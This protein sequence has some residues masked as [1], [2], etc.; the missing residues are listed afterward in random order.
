VAL[1]QIGT[2]EYLEYIPGS[3]LYLNSGAFTALPTDDPFAAWANPAQISNIGPR[4]SAG[5]Y[6]TKTDVA[7]YLDNETNYQSYSVAAGGEKG[8]FQYGVGLMH[9]GSNA[10]AFGL[11]DDFM[12][13]LSAGIGVDL[14]LQMNT[15]ITLKNGE[16]TAV[17]LGI[18]L[19]YPTPRF[20]KTSAEMSVGYAML[21][22]GSSIDIFGREYPYPRSQSLGYS[23]ALVHHFITPKG[24]ERTVRLDVSVD[25]N[26]KLVEP[27][28]PY[29]SEGRHWRYTSVLG[30]INV[31]DHLILRRSGDR[32]RIS[33]GWRLHIFDTFRIGRGRTEGQSHYLVN[34]SN[35]YEI[36]L[37]RVLK[38]TYD[39][40][41]PISLVYSYSTASFSAQEQVRT[42]Q[43]VSLGWGF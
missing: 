38:F 18:Q 1:G 29:P 42:F 40:D 3:G 39:F 35:G 13:A 10:R 24:P 26:D 12:T 41:T 15:G 20:M 8:R 28:W 22:M 11:S 30:N 43:G 25:I 34:H 14:G 19:T 16:F 31:R 33:Q 5:I 6:S 32:I 2:F 23:L 27:I 9:T 4:L 17:D 7:P 36:D 37:T 21:N